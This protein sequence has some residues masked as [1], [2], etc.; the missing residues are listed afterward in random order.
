MSC[1]TAQPGSLVPPQERTVKW[2][3]PA[4]ITTASSTNSRVGGF[5]VCIGGEIEAEG[6]TSVYLTDESLPILVQVQVAAVLE[7]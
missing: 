5:Q 7:S 1:S 3:P 6:A 2:F 4:D